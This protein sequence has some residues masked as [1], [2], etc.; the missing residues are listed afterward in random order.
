MAP[1]PSIVPRLGDIGKNGDETWAN[2][3]SL[4]AIISCRLSKSF[5]KE[6]IVPD[7]VRYFS[8]ALVVPA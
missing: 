4:G 3:L 6:P 2:I 1:C 5:P 7:R 8:A